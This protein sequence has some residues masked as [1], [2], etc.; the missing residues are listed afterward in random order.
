MTDR[1]TIDLKVT[2]VLDDKADLTSVEFNTDFPDAN[3]DDIIELLGIALKAAEGG[4]I[5]ET[6]EKEEEND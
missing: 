6:T 4:P 2:Y 3:G 1:H 5:I